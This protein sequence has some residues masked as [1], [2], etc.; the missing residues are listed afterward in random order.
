MPQDDHKGPDYEERNYR[1]GRDEPR[2]PESEGSRCGAPCPPHYNLLLFA[3]TVWGTAPSAPR[4]CFTSS[5]TCTAQ[6]GEVA[7]GFSSQLGPPCSSESALLL[8][9]ALTLCLLLW[10]LPLLLRHRRSVVTACPHPTTTRHVGRYN[11]PSYDHRGDEPREQHEGDDRPDEMPDSQGLDYY[12]YMGES[13]DELR[14]VS[15]LLCCASLSRVHAP[16]PAACA[17]T[18][19]VC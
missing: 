15:V 17:P 6:W 5:Q 2:Y 13:R 19:L 10:L 14:E 7:A 1:G 11:R 18:A 16:A 3:H 8:Q 4:S 9:C 12:K